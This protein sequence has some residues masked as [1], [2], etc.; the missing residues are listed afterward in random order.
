MRIYFVKLQEIKSTNYCLDTIE[1]V[2]SNHFESENKLLTMLWIG[3]YENPEGGGRGDSNPKLF[4]G[5]N[6]NTG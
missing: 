6:Y 3:R 4:E 1:Y 5:D 2:N